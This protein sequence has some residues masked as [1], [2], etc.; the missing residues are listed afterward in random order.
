MTGKGK[1][2]WNPTTPQ[3]IIKS[4]TIIDSLKIYYW[5]DSLAWCFKNLENESVLQDIIIINPDDHNWP[6]I[7]H[8]FNFGF[9]LIFC[10]A[11]G[12]EIICWLFD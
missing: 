12:W 8:S 4:E 10:S 11:D 2:D 6:Q 5:L 3:E 7:L 1:M 9:G